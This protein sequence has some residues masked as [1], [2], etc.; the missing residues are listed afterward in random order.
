VERPQEPVPVVRVGGSRSPATA[1]IAAAVVLLV[2][3]VAKPW[4]ATAAHGVPAPIPA[5]DAAVPSAAAEPPATRAATGASIDGQAA[6]GGVTSTTSASTPGSCCS[7][8]TAPTALVEQGGMPVCYS[9]DGWRI[10][11]DQMV[12]GRKSRVWLPVTPVASPSPSP[13][14]PGVA[15]ARLVADRVT[16]LGFCAPVELTSSGGW[17]AIVWSDRRPDVGSSAGGVAGGAAAALEP[18]ATLRATARTDGALSHGVGAPAAWAP[19]RYLLEVQRGRAPGVIDAW[20]ALDL[21]APAP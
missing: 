10:V 21:V 1:V 16:A 18:L 3:A 5:V 6:T 17:Q 4:Q 14:G 15:A 2:C 12:G 19:G 20:L 13:G 7:I 11:A 9:P 8:A